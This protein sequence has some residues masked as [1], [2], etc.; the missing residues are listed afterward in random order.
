MAR[1]ILIQSEQIS[2]IKL[3]TRFY[4]VS[5]DYSKNRIAVAQLVV[6]LSG[7]QMVVGS[8]P[9]R[10][11]HIYLIAGLT[12]H[13]GVVNASSLSMTEYKNAEPAQMANKRALK[14]DSKLP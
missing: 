10:G 9:V 7:K 5:V 3:Q 4:H 11:T 8:N 12:A 14:F 1:S 13:H 6:H 2:S